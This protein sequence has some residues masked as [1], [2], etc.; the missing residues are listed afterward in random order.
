MANRERDKKGGNFRD[1]FGG[2]G[3]S[4]KERGKYPQSVTP[5]PQSEDFSDHLDAAEHMLVTLTDEEINNEFEKMLDDMNLSE[6]KKE[7]LR[8]RPMMLKKE[9]LSMHL[10]GNPPKGSNRSQFDSPENY[11]RFLSNPEMSLD[12]LLRGIESLRIALTNN[13]ISWVVEFGNNGLD[14]LLQILNACYGRENRYEKIQHECIKCLKAIMNNTAGLKQV[15][16]HKDALTILARSINFSQPNI[17][18]DAVKLMAAVCLI[19]PSGHERV[20]EAITTSAE[21]EE[22]DRFSAI[23]QG[24]G[25]KDNDALRGSCFALINCIVSTPDDLE[26]KLHLRNEFMRSGL[27]D[28][29]EDLQAE[30]GKEQDSKTEE[31]SIQLK[32]FLEGKDEDHDEFLQRYDLVRFEMDEPIECFEL[33]KQTVTDTTAEPYFLSILQHLLLIRDDALARPAYYKLIEECISQIVLHKSGCDPDFRSSKHF[34]IDVEPLIE[35]LVERAKQEEEKQ[36]QELTKKLEEAVTAK[37]EADAKLAQAEQKLVE[38]ENQLNEIKSTGVVPSQKILAP[39]PPPPPGSGIPPPPPL[40]GST[41]PPPP[42]LP[43]VRGIPPPPPPPPGGGPPPP[44]PP[45]GLGGL[46][47]NVPQGSPSP[48]A[49]DVLPFGIKPKKK[50]HLETPLK[51]AN[52]KKIQPQKLS[53]KSFWVKVDEETLADEDVLDSLTLKFSSAPP[54]KKPKQQTEEKSVKKAKELKVLDSKSAQNLM[55]LLGSVKM[56][57]QEMKDMILC[58]NEDYLTDAMLQQ[59]I[60]YMPEPDQLKKLDDFKNQYDDLAEAEQFAITMGSIKRLVPRL[61]SM[62]FKL[63][64][65]EK[66]QDIKP[67][68]VAATA[69]CEEVKN[70]EKFSLI[71]KL[72]L[73]IGNIMNSGSKNGQAIGFEVSFLPKLSGTKAQDQKTTLMQFLADIVE[74]K[75]PDALNFGEELLHVTR[76]ARVSP[77]QIQ[78]NLSQMKKS[79]QQLETDLKNFR[80]Q[81]DN[82]RFEEV[83]SS[84]LTESSKQYELLDSMYNKMGKL[85]EDIAEYFAFDPKKYT[86]DE[87]FGD[88]KA[89]KESFQEAHKENVKIREVEE[90]IR[91]AK[92]AKEKADKEK[93]ERQEMKRQLIDISSGEDQEGVMDNLL[94]ALKTGSAFSHKPRKRVPRAAGAERRAQL[95]R[96]RSRTAINAQDDRDLDSRER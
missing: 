6:E 94:E 8:S 73:L 10:K 1:M 90:K 57:S 29:L 19:P 92:E 20:L 80:P 81:S 75:H 22:R 35:N 4:K 82:D 77:E 13:P 26:F 95:N 43:G 64:F 27:S 33:I 25:R 88:I 31:L 18:V 39:P 41:I 32:V 48:V 91:R 40:P 67:D 71:L 7:P 15:F 14:K 66:V 51:K 36:S 74:K 84:F 60:R 86:L 17:M 49:M 87:F 65:A 76:A 37:Q 46:R 79:I 45:P 85:Y 42:P 53:E 83:M 34:K 21:L 59:L 69:A 12:K 5:R 63:N 78:K 52:W 55:I 24:L 62:S 38:I 72:I 68:I 93:Q 89:F 23:V 54:A 70:S 50:Y 44:P 28:I 11:V 16:T 9:M 30:L 3:K 61:K 47:F 2:L 56:S 58:I 96:N